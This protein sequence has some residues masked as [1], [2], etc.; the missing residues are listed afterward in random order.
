MSLTNATFPNMANHE[1]K[2]IELLD[3]VTNLEKELRREYAGPNRPG[4]VAD[5]HQRI[6]R[7][8]KK[9]D[10]HATH[11]LRQAVQDL[12]VST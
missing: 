9:A 8:L 11:A 12:A 6:N 3:E 4:R 5:L 10:I 7:C 2:S 1:Q